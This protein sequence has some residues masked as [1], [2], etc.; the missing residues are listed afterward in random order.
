MDSVSKSDIDK[1]WGEIL[2][3]HRLKLGLTQEDLAEKIG[4]SVK[5]I[6]KI[7][8]GKSGIKTQTLIKYINI[9]G[10]TP[11]TIYK[12]FIKNPEVLSSIEL[13]DKIEELSE[14]E[15]ICASNI[16]DEIKKIK[17]RDQKRMKLFYKFHS[18]LFKIY[19][20]QKALYVL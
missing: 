13:S 7:E 14:D 19:S 5:Y 11:N 18:F 20:F 3:N 16:I 12:S 4:I 8:T 6:S 9:L 10:I 15:K 2:K 1:N 17:N